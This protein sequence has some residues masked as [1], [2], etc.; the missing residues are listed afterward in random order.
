M[1]STP[2]SPEPGT[3]LS[4]L[5]SDLGEMS[6]YTWMGYGYTDGEYVTDPEVFDGL[7]YMICTTESSRPGFR[8]MPL[9]SSIEVALETGWNLIG[10]MSGDSTYYDF[11][12]CEV[13]H[14]GRRQAWSGSGALSH[15]VVWWEDETGNLQ[16][17]GLWGSKAGSDL[18]EA[19]PSGLNLWGGFYVWADE[20]C[21]LILQGSAK[22]SAERRL[23]AGESTAA[24]RIRLFVEQGS[25]R[26]GWIELGLRED[27]SFGRDGYD[28]RK[29][30]FPAEGVRISIDHHDWPGADA[31][32][33][34]TDFRP[35]GEALYSW[36]LSLSGA[37]DEDDVAYL[38]WFD[39][40][41]IDPEWYVYLIDE[42]DRAIDMRTSSYLE[43]DL[44]GSIEKMIAIRMQREPWDGAALY[45]GPSRIQAIHP[46]PSRGAVSVRFSTGK[47][48][49]V[50]V[51][52]YDVQGRLVERIFD[53][54]IEPGEYGAE[55]T[56]NLSGVASGVYFVRLETR[57]GADSRSFVVIE[58]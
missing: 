13:E 28:V 7:A 31:G 46:S 25:T 1:V 15:S 42:K 35:H 53:G 36:R 27:C 40:E 5:L 47:V 32:S 45:T 4:D 44:D 23:A 51:S 6:R 54:E 38:R 52:V 55:W 30:P 10:V 11:A 22:R 56:P 34:L 37:N 16:N 21:T 39:V 48:G 2:V 50:R 29:P 43:L 9:D 49:R 33:Y 14:G 57:A 19:D 18:F 17:D 20:A 24:S 41:S 8:G 12:S 26:D 58:Q 3:R